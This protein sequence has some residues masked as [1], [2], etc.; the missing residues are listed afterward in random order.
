MLGYGN[1][2]PCTAGGKVFTIIFALI[3]IPLTLV[4]LDNI[5]SILANSAGLC[6]SRF[7]RCCV[8]F[9]NRKSNP[10][11]KK[12][13]IVNLSSIPASSRN[14][15]SDVLPLTLGFII[16]ILWLIIM[17]VYFFIIENYSWYFGDCLYF[18][19]ISITTIGR[20]N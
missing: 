5:G 13:R 7:K 18:V 12:T 1:V 14:K 20:L 19:L 10:A 16:T 9:K 17:A 15:K 6:W 3:G 2:Y 11:F 4:V 8:R